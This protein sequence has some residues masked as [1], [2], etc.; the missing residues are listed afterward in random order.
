M[1]IWYKN[2]DGTSKRPLL[3]G[4]VALGAM[5]AYV[6]PASA[7]LIYVGNP[8]V[9]GGVGNSQVV[10]SL[11]SPG[12]SSNEIAAINPAGCTGDFLGACNNANNS[13]RTLSSAGVTSAANLVVYLDAQEPANDNLI[14]LNSLVLNV[15]AATGS[16]TVALFSAPFGGAVPL[17]L[18]VCPGQGNNCVNAFVL[19]ATEA[20]ELQS[21]FT[22]NLRVGFSGNFSNATGGP[23]RL[24]LANHADVPIPTPE[25]ASL[26]LFGVGLLGLS[27]LRRGR[28]T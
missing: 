25:P 26:A 7:N 19:D 5:M 11:Q 1:S 10:L 24:F 15:Y 28:R 8:T 18:T 22:P 3:K 16:S 2:V 9:A 27:L 4:A 23:D 21:I 12:S 20:A 14:T 6:A 17:N 13:L